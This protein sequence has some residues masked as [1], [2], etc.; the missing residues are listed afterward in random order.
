[1]SGASAVA[2]GPRTVLTASHVGAG[3][4]V[5][6]GITYAATST[7]VAPN[8]KGSKVDLRVVQL[9]SD[10]PGWFGLG[11]TAPT[12]ATVTMVGY[13]GTG[14]LNASGNGYILTK[15]GTRR[16][17]ENQITKHTSYKGF[18][19]T[20]TSMLNRAGESALAGGDSGGGWFVE[21][22]LVGISAFTFTKNLRKPNYG[23]SKSAYFGSGAIDLTNR[24]IAGW[25][26]SQ[27]AAVPTTRTFGEPQAVPEPASFATLL[28]GAAA[29]LRRRRR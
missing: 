12:N 3:A 16:S 24:S 14:M 13:G 2:V 5:L 23:W 11:T 18:G 17:G 9:A 28:V 8:V 7:A 22:K 10:L 21:G 15:G 1:M 19:P 27:I 29:L 4:F 6:D 26:T 25:V 20:I